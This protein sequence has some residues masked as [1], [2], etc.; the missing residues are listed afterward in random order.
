MSDIKNPGTT[1]EQA[2]AIIENEKR[3]DRFIRL[4]N[5]VAWTSTF[6]IAGIIAT[7]V[8]VQVVEL[9][10][11]G[12]LGAL[13]WTSVVAAAMPFLDIL[14]KLSLLIAALSTVGIFLRLRTAS[15]TEIQLRLAT[16]E[17]ML[18]SRES[19][20]GGGSA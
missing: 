8:G 9:A 3:R 18:A 14:W 17:S 16:L 10:K 2:W 7:L 5:I 15:L 13:P 12:M 19:G 6:L 1:S 11:G 4:V 20:P